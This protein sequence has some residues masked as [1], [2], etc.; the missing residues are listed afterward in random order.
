MIRYAI[1]VGAR[2]GVDGE[3]LVALALEVAGEFGVELRRARLAT[4]D[5][6]ANE[7]G[8][9]AAAK[10]LGMELL[11][12]PIEILRRR[13]AEGLTRSPRIEELFG[14]GSI[15]ETAALTGAGERSVLLAPRTAAKKLTCAIARGRWGGAED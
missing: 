13:G 5:A 3:A 8:I 14:V 4:I 1:G 6:R 9:H 11:F 12:F 15:A 10:T 7:D 2:A